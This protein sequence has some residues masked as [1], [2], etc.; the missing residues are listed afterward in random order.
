MRLRATR[1]DQIELRGLLISRFRV[2]PSTSCLF[3]QQ[4][5]TQQ[6]HTLHYLSPLPSSIH[7]QNPY[8]SAPNT[9]HHQP[10]HTFFHPPRPPSR[11]NSPRP[12]HIHINQT[13]L[14]P[15]VLC[16]RTSSKHPLPPPQFLCV[17]SLLG[18]PH[19]PPHTHPA[20]ESPRDTVIIV[21]RCRRP[22]PLCLA[23]AASSA[24]ETSTDCQQCARAPCGHG[25]CSLRGPRPVSLSI[26]IF[27]LSFSFG[28]LSSCPPRSFQPHWT[29]FPLLGYSLLF[30]LLNCTWG[31]EK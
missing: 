27:S 10:R 18:L 17:A 21:H 25:P 11:M 19:P 16:Q 22:C 29:D 24:S 14:P 1:S 30:F 4:L 5:H 2:L 26:H 6:N 13:P 12:A 23:V 28:L 9:E 8:H 20:S 15:L 7:A 31:T 3:L